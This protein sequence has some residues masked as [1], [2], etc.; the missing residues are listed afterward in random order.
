ML[1]PIAEDRFIEL[2]RHNKLKDKTIQFLLNE[3]YDSLEA[4]RSMSMEQFGRLTVQYSITEGQRGLLA[5]WIADIRVHENQLIYGKHT[6]HSLRNCTMKNYLYLFC[7]INCRL[8][9]YKHQ[10]KNSLHVS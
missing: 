4:L 9:I 8:F 5:K 1:N 10:E 7:G 2:A 3:D 6:S